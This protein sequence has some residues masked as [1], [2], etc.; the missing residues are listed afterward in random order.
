MPAVATP[1]PR[2][3]AHRTGCRALPTSLPPAPAGTMMVRSGDADGMVSGAMCTTANTIRPAL[4]VGL[5]VWGG[6]TE[7]RAAVGV[8]S[9]V[10]AGMVAGLRGSLPV[11]QPPRATVHVPVAEPHVLPLVPPTYVGHACGAARPR[12]RCSRRPRGR[13]SPP[14]S[15]CACQTRCGQRVCVCVWCVCVVCV[16]VWWWGLWWVWWGAGDVG[17]L[18][19]YLTSK[20]QLT[21]AHPRDMV[22]SAA[23]ASCRAARR[24][25][26]G[27]S[28]QPGLMQ[29]RSCQNNLARTLHVQVLVYGDC[30]VNVEPKPEELAQV[31]CGGQGCCCG[32]DMQGPRP[33]LAAAQPRAHTHTHAHFLSLTH[34]RPSPADRH[35]VCRH[36]RRLWHHAARRADELLNRH[37]RLG[38][39]GVCVCVCV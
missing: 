11:W 15:S 6:V 29:P 17:S 36:R 34:T 5:G 18:R 26:P 23:R 14:S 31:G 19:R 12:R 22:G 25:Q 30:A 20:H 10:Y 32:G 39:A 3:A 16:C 38:A 2:P 7:G 9:T 4:Q 28:T 27:C 1:Q 35:R 33:A 8:R 37:L 13:W 24:P 21:P